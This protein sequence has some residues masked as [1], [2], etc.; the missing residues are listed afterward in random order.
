MSNIFTLASI[1][2]DSN[3]SLSLFTESEIKD[4]ESKITSKD[5]K[6]HINCIIRNKDILLKPEEIIRQLYAAKLIDK[7]G[8]P[9][10]RIKFESCRP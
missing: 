1:L 7:Y 10:N 6:A 5:G 4:L 8:Y 3:Y 2:K 9:K